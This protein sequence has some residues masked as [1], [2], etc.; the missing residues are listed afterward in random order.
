MDDKPLILEALDKWQEM[1]DTGGMSAVEMGYRWVA[2]HSALDASQGDGLVIGALSVARW[3]S[4]LAAVEK[5]PLD[6]ETAAKIDGLWT[7]DF[8]AVDDYD[9]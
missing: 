9:V 8:K 1:A 7:P 4:Y 2:H 6:A 3:Q 5:G